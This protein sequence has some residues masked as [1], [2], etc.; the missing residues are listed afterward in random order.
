MRNA[1]S[2]F[3]MFNL[4]ECNKHQKIIVIDFGSKVAAM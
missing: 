3:D 4:Q 1:K 2:V